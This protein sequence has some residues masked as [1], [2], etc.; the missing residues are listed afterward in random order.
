[1]KILE[2]RWFNS[3]GIVRVE[4]ECDGI[5]YYIKYYIHGTVNKNSEDEYKKL[6]AEWGSRFP[7]DA[8]DVLFGIK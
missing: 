3:C 5:K 8:G 2:A 6:I 7:N 4:T 1:M